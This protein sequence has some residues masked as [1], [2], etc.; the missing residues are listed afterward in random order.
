MQMRGGRREWRGRLCPTTVLSEERRALL[1]PPRL[2]RLH[3]DGGRGRN[4]RCKVIKANVHH[5]VGDLKAR[6]FLWFTFLSFSRTFL[7]IDFCLLHFLLVPH[8]PPLCNLE[9]TRDKF[10]GRYETPLPHSR[11]FHSRRFSIN[12]PSPFTRITRS[13]RI[14]S[15]I[16]FDRSFKTIP[17]PL[18]GKSNSLSDFYLFIY[19]LLRIERIKGNNSFSVPRN[20][21]QFRVPNCP[22]LRRINRRLL[23]R[24]IATS[25]N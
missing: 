8:P 14:Y 1:P 11:S 2:E 21:I 13:I 22:R 6:N 5:L 25:G 4:E 17:S 12:L 10:A 7:R 3:D 18:R 23:Q 20:V 15:S 9:I 24:L 16:Q 19:F